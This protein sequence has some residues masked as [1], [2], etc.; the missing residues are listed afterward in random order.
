MVVMSI[1]RCLELLGAVA[2]I[3]ITFPLDGGAYASPDLHVRAVLDFESLMAGEA[4][5][6][7]NGGPPSAMPRLVTDWYTYMNDD[8]HTGCSEAPAPHSDVVLW[9]APVT[10][11]YH[12]FPN[13]VIVEGI[14]Y[15][16]SNSG[17]D[18]LYALDALTGEVLW[19]YRVGST[20]DAVTVKDGLLWIASDSLWCLDALTGQRIWASAEGDVAASTPVVSDGWVYGGLGWSEPV[21]CRLD[22]MTGE[23]DWRIGLP[24]GYTVSCMTRWGDLLL[25]P[26]S[27]G[28]LYALDAAT[29]GIVWENDDALEGYWDSSPVVV[30][31]LIYIGDMDGYLRAIEPET[32][33]TV[34]QTP[35]SLEPGVGVTS[36]PSCGDGILFAGGED[37]PVGAFSAD[38]GDAQWTADFPIHG[39]SCMAD[40]LVFFCEYFSEPANGARVVALDMATGGIS[41]LHQFD[42]DHLQST[43]AVT[44]GVMYVAATDGLLY[45]FGTGLEYTYESPMTAQVGWNDLV[46]HATIPGGTILSDTISFLV[47]PSCV[48]EVAPAH[49]GMPVLRILGNPARGVASIVLLSRSHAQARIDLF[50]LGGRS[51]SSAVLPAGECPQVDL[52]VSGFPAG[53]YLVRCVQDDMSGSVKLTI[54]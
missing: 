40:G 43:P 25:V 33:T 14:V 47:D 52:D 13:P 51:L 28:P 10:G 5:F 23:L 37:G 2:G 38:T 29:G 46:V 19:K 8:L 48:G 24:D 39:S 41:W 35:V 6:V 21:V 20:D 4:G 34:W 9:T 54:L 22:A 50:D 49:A 53:V 15:Y 27:D 31:G 26:T 1:V 32:G 42:A 18:S 17:T 11:P 12:E 44:D 45:A 30:D 3:E 7:L 36:T 16:P